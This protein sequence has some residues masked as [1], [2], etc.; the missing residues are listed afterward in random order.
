MKYLLLFIVLFLP[1]IGMEN[2]TN[3]SK[4]IFLKKA[5]SVFQ[6]VFFSENWSFEIGSTSP[7]N[8]KNIWNAYNTL[9]VLVNYTSATSD[10]TYLDVIKEYAGNFEAYND[11]QNAGYDDAQWC[12][13]AL[14]K[15]YNLTKDSSYL[16]RAKETWEYIKDDSWDSATCSGGCWWNIEETYKNA[17]TNELFIVYSSLMFIETQEETYK[18]WAIKTWEWFDNSGMLAGHNSIKTRTNLVNDGINKKCLN[19]NG[20]IW[21]YN[22]GVIIGGLTYLWKITQDKK[23]IMKAIDIANSSIA[24]LTQDGI[25]VE[26]PDGIS[27]LPFMDTDQQQFKGIFVRYLSELCEAL[28]NDSKDKILFNQFIEKNY[29]KLLELYPDLKFG[30]LWHKKDTS[31]NYNVI[32]QTSGIDL[33]LAGFMKD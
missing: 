27:P 15:T 12:G 33:M 29:N 32:S 13:I 2:N 18:N 5:V 11:A 3:Q 1:S 26:K 20:P 30:T 28:P 14:L 4:L 8:H 22:Q 7:W 31:N 25:L 9:E 21:T 23:Y 24:N 16:V 6:E 19:N 17:I 10:S